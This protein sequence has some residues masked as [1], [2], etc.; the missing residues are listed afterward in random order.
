VS[1]G[2]PEEYRRS[3][4]LARQYLRENKVDPSQLERVDAVLNYSRNQI[5]LFNLADPANE[6]SVAETL[7]HESIH[8]LLDQVGEIWAART[9]DRVTK[10]VR[11]PARRGGI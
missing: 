8:S 11:D 1:V 3:T 4:A 2:S 5:T 6:L 10:H 7:S 9:L